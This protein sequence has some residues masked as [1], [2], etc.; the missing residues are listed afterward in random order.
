LPAP[1]I[2]AASN[3]PIVTLEVTPN[4]AGAEGVEVE[5]V[6]SA[7]ASSGGGTVSEEQERA[8]REALEAVKD[9]G[10]LIGLV[11]SLDRALR[12]P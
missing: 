2:D 6:F 12:R 4:G 10:S 1:H 7:S 9:K 8:V 5:V 11:V 3:P